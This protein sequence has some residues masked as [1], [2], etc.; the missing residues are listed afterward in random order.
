MIKRNKNKN[1]LK[2]KKRTL[3]KFAFIHFGE[4]QRHERQENRYDCFH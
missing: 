2:K 4:P 1:K 3:L